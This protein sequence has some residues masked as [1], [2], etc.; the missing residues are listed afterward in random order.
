MLRFIAEYEGHAVCADLDDG[1]QVMAACE[2]DSPDLVFLELHLPG[3][4][5]LE[6]LADFRRASC[7]GW[8]R[9]AGRAIS[10]GA[11]RGSWWSRT[12]R[13]TGRS[14]G[15]W[16]PTPAPSWWARRA[17]RPRAGGW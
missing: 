9:G 5:G 10:R 12:S 4:T 16:W 2:A 1:L 13:P 14:C 11:R 17:P 8:R 7:A 15:W 3:R 6:L